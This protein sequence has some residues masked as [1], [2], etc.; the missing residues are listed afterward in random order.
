MNRFI[1]IVLIAII[2]F[3]ALVTNPAHAQNHNPFGRYYDTGNDL[4]ASLNAGYDSPKYTQAL[5]YIKGVADATY[6]SVHCS[7]TSVTVGQLADLVQ[8]QLASRADIRHRS[9]ALHVSA[10][11]M[12]NFP[13]P[14][15]GGV[16][17]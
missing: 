7:P 8:S 17:L 16:S 10:T 11:L 9:A 2:G 5:G 4:Y 6:G 12:T 1:A 15:Q 13:C 14:R 3:I